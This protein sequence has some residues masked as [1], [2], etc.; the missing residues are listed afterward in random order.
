[1]SFPETRDQLRCLWSPFRSLCRSNA[2][3]GAVGVV[4]IPLAISVFRVLSNHF[5]SLTGGWWRW[6][7]QPLVS[8]MEL[9]VVEQ[10]ESN[11][12]EFFGR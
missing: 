8:G 2:G 7:Q 3:A 1:M 11:Q 9:A 4:G 6:Y 10:E 12:N 5:G